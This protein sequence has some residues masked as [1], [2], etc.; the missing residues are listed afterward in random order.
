[1]EQTFSSSF[2]GGSVPVRTFCR[3]KNAEKQVDPPSNQFS[4]QRRPRKG[5][6]PPTINRRSAFV[7]SREPTHTH[8]HT[9]FHRIKWQVR[10]AAASFNG[11][12]IEIIRHKMK[13]QLTSLEMFTYQNVS[14]IF[15]LSKNFAL[16]KSA[17]FLFVCRNLWCLNARKWSGKSVRAWRIT[18]TNWSE[19][20]FT[21]VSKCW[22][23]GSPPGPIF[24]WWPTPPARRRPV[25]SGRGQRTVDG[26]GLG[27]GLLATGRCPIG[28]A[29]ESMSSQS[30]P[31]VTHSHVTR[32]HATF[33]LPIK[34]FVDS[35]F[36]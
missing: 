32:V 10:T 11:I 8:T 5:P 16:Q 20:F 13:F 29:A 22:C 23:T 31:A 18:Y 9:C 25:S 28:W 2:C 4:S 19:R 6:G 24:P 26:W 34:F 7:S 27:L 36:L 17:E 33:A 30:A 3:I 15:T 14:E 21:T 12:F 1:M 35:F